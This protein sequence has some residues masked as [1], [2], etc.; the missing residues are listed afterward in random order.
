MK[1]LTDISW[2][3]DEPTYRADKALS[4]SN[5]SHYE[6][7]GKFSAIPTLF[8]KITTPS[9]VFGSMVDT[10]MTGSEE[11]FQQQFVIID[12]PGISDSLKEIT[13]NLYN[14][15]KDTR[16]RFEDIPDDVLAR[17]G[18]ECNYYAKD[19]YAETRVRKIK[20]SC[21]PYFNTLFIAEG[22][23][24]VTQ[25]DVEDARRC[26]Q[27][28]RTNE[29]TA[30]YFANN[31]PF[32]PDVERFYQLKFKTTLEGLDLRCMADLIVVSHKSKTVQPCDLKTSST[33]EW[34][35]PRA[36]QQW[37]YDIQAR[38][39]WR[40]IRKVMDQDE[41]FKDFKLLPF[42]FIVV[43]RTSCQPM[44]WDFPMTEALGEIN[45]ET[46]S[47]YKVIWRDPYVIGKELK[48]YLDEQPPIPFDTD[49][50]IVHWLKTN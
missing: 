14:L 47:G 23:N 35:F 6:K 41:Y 7:G 40:I 4:Y 1:S 28:L 26:A 16:L 34:E 11:D 39:Y 19:N 31:D 20:E 13:M 38:L 46:P 48:K 2:L 21:K 49:R 44:V 27:A 17:V 25:T 15:Y 24:V 32:V 36:F 30:F 5:L 10:L 18:K 9:L 45:F 43:N 42:K 29:R 22:K 37:R 3:V 33:N 12:D 50:D 8:D